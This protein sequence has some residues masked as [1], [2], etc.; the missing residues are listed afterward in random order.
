MIRNIAVL[1]TL[2]AAVG[3]G[4]SAASTQASIARARLEVRAVLN[5]T[6][7]ADSIARVASRTPR[8]Q[9]V[10][11]ASAVGIQATF[12][13][14]PSGGVSAELVLLASGVR[15]TTRRFVTRS[16]A[17]AA[18]AVALMVAV[19]LDPVWVSEHGSAATG[20]SGTSASPGRDSGASSTPQRT[21][22]PTGGLA[23]QPPTKVQ[24]QPLPPPQVPLP[25][26]TATDSTSTPA[27]RGQPRIGV[28]LAGQSVWGPAPA[29]MPG[30]AVYAVV[31]LDRDTI[32]SPAIVLGAFHVWRSDLAEPGGSASFSL[33]AGSS[34][35]LRTSCT[36]VYRR[37][38]GLRGGA[39]RSSVG[40]RLGHGRTCVGR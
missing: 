14:A 21:S 6:S 29:V 2:L 3:S 23:A 7:P 17:E 12:T 8:I 1:A 28:Y 19:A 9:F 22:A 26:R 16:C 33:D 20:E 24:E 15:R 10:D 30:V 35:C 32:W 34:G 27:L 31:G 40:R 11:D 37:C 25:A 39:D 5:G 36:G 4:A 38:A 18:D 13:V